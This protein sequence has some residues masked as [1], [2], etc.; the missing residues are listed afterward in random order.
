MLERRPI[1]RDR[2]FAFYSPQRSRLLTSK[3]IMLLFP[4]IM[5][6]RT[7]SFVDRC[8][9]QRLAEGSP[10][11]AQ[12][13]ICMEGRDL[14]LPRRPETGGFQ[15]DRRLHH[16]KPEK[17]HFVIDAP[18][19]VGVRT[20][21]PPRC[22][23][24]STPEWENLPAKSEGLPHRRWLKFPRKSPYDNDADEFVRLVAVNAGW[25]R[26]EWAYSPLFIWGN[27]VGANPGFPAARWLGRGVS[28][29]D[30]G[31]LRRRRNDGSQAG[32]NSGGGGNGWPPRTGWT[33]WTWSSSAPQRSASSAFIWRRTP[34]GARS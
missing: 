18:R 10:G 8:V 17:R 13:R 2:R 15:G 32:R 3:T 11:V 1:G 23:A 28:G 25:R 26:D 20:D 7:C 16:A 6:K 30:S 24:F 19:D 34:R 12:G 22:G 9:G 21:F 33:W 27:S 14:R 31:R 4:V 5:C 29:S